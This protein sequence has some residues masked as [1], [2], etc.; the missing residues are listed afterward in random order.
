MLRGAHDR[1][2]RAGVQMTA[3]TVTV[4]TPVHGRCDLVARLL[5]SLSPAVAAFAA[6]GGAADV[7]LVD[8]TP[9]ADRER[10]AALA[11]RHGAGV[12][13]AG[14]DV[15]RKRNLGIRH[16]R[17]DIVLFVDSDCEADPRLIVEHAAAH[18]SQ[19]AP[20]GRPVAGVVGAV[21]LAGT[22]TAAWRAAEAAG[23]C[24]GFAF[25]TRYPQADW[26]PCANVSYR[27]DVL[28]GIGGFRE[29]W[30]RRLGGDDVELGLRVNAT[31]GA[32]LCHPA[33][34]VTHSRSTWARWP[35]VLER[36]WRWG[37][38]DAH[39]RAAV[40]ASR[41]RPGGAGPALLV[42]VAALT[43]V[44]EAA[45]LRAPRPLARAAIALPLAL[46]VDGRPARPVATGLAGR[47]LQLVFDLAALGESIRIGRPAL[48]FAALHPPDPH[49]ARR[50]ARRRSAATTAGLAGVLALVLDTARHRATPGA[51]KH[52]RMR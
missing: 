37:A 8:S 22:R 41:R 43:A 51:R 35:A 6:A 50:R 31:R 49:A 13:R 29:D 34:A 18:R 44:A 45:R 12:I 16:A 21:R 7:I 15:R 39:V 27:R 32:I 48:A 46:L 4:V 10:I 25:A 1:A 47:A 52:P 2:A 24:D 19:R 17:G 28:V 23:F 33:A 3:G 9:G 38:M 26:A 42:A 5:E 11:C 40:P 14:N 20:D 36:A 30:P